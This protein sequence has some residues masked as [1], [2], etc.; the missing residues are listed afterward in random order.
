MTREDY[1]KEFCYMPARNMRSGKFHAGWKGIKHNKDY[2]AL[3]YW[4]PFP[5]IK[6]YFLECFLEYVGDVRPRLMRERRARGLPDHPFLLVSSGSAHHEDDDTSAGDPYTLAALKKSW[7]RAMQRLQKLFPESDLR[8]RKDSGTS[9]H[10]LRHHYGASLARIG[11]TRE[12]IQECM[13]HI[14]PNSSLVYTKPIPSEV[15]SILSAA[16]ERGTGAPLL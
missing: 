4:G 15:H 2:Y 11:M 10:G 1:L 5:G 14:H 3:M 9:L 13:H 6:E 16:Q 7:R 12:Q 8:V